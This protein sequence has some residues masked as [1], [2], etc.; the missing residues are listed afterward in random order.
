[1][2]VNASTRLGCKSIV[3]FLCCL[4][5]DVRGVV[6]QLQEEGIPCLGVATDEAYATAG[7]AITTFRIGSEKD[8]LPLVFAILVDVRPSLWS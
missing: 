1:M 4:N 2:I 3:G 6:G 8:I 7:D 5:V